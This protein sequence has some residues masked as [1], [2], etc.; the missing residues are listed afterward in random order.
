M[1]VRLEEKVKED[2]K[3]KKDSLCCRMLHHTHHV[4]HGLM[5]DCVSAM[6]L[7]HCDALLCWISESRVM[8]RTHDVKKK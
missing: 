8:R 2:E 6:V 5:M 4:R 1:G 3:R 7:Y